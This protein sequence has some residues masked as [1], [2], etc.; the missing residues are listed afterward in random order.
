VPEMRCPVFGAYGD[1]DPG[2]PIESVRD[3]EAALQ[4]HGKPH[5]IHVYAGAPHAF[6]NDQRDS[7]RELAA[8]DAW[9]RVLR[10]FAENLRVPQAAGTQPS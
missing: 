5:Q 9:R 4:K 2:I 8:A 7:Y 10:F 3:L 6:M 1:A